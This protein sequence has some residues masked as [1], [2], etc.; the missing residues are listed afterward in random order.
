M[1]QVS[2]HLFTFNSDVCVKELYFPPQSRKWT[3]SVK[4]K[5]TGGVEVLQV[6]K[7]LPRRSLENQIYLDFH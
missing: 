5:D 3:A 1:R 2:I 4:S 6:L 7:I